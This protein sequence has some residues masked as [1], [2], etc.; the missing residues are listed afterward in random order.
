MTYG[1][2]T[3]LLSALPVLSTPGSNGGLRW[4]AVTSQGTTLVEIPTDAPDS[5]QNTNG[6]V[7]GKTISLLK[8]TS[9]QYVNLKSIF[10]KVTAYFSIMGRSLAVWSNISSFFTR[11]HSNYLIVIDISKSG[12]DFI[13]GQA[14]LKRFYCL[15]YCHLPGRTGDNKLPDATTNWDNYESL[16][17]V[18]KFSSRFSIWHKKWKIHLDSH[19]KP[20]DIPSSF[21]QRWDSPEQPRKSSL[22]FSIAL[23]IE[24]KNWKKQWAVRCVRTNKYWHI[25]NAYRNKWISEYYAG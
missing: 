22:R 17:P 24:C 6:G 14:F 19:I 15:R 5:Y 21:G 4:L 23:R 8:F 16:R 12:L 13:L 18:T 25:D 11:L 7:L 3:T 10:I 9:T 2:D 1:G 20:L